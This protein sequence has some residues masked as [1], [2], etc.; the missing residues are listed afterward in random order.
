MDPKVYF[1]AE[2]KYNSITDYVNICNND[3]DEEKYINTLKLLYRH[4]YYA[5]DENV[6]ITIIKSKNPDYINY[7]FNYVST[8]LHEDDKIDYFK[9]ELLCQYISKKEKYK[10]LCCN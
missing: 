5:Y 8:I 2:I 7:E 4:I 3:Y 10:G 9:F 6:K 1:R